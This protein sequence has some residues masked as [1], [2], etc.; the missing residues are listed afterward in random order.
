LLKDAFLIYNKLKI[1]TVDKLL[2]SEFKTP[3]DQFILY[4]ETQPFKDVEM[5]AGTMPNEVLNFMKSWRTWRETEFILEI[6]EPCCI[7]PE[8]GWAIVKYNQLVY[9]SLAMSRTWFQPKPNLYKFWRRTNVIRAKR[10]LSLRDTGEENYFHFYNDVLCKIFFLQQQNIEIR[11]VPLIISKKLWDKEYFQFYFKNSEL[12]QSLQWIIQD[13]QYIECESSI[14]CKPLTHQI[15]LWNSIFAPVVN[16]KASDQHRRI[17]LTRKKSRLR[18]IENV[19]EIELILKKFG[20]EIIDTDDFTPE[21]QKKIFFDTEFLVGIHGAGLTNMI[22]R[23]GNCRL[24]EVFPP[25]DQ[26]YLPYHYIM[27][28]KMLGFQYSAI[29]GER[30]KALYSGGFYMSPMRIEEALLELVKDELS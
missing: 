13:R 18:F 22:F 15:K 8:F 11:T 23:I 29:I 2:F 5:G 1:R 28:A 14:F 17:F 4:S 7:E 3:K 12:L 25:P 19:D 10:A 24:L 16:K 20:F 30:G 27:L 9:S 26:G 21:E 6:N